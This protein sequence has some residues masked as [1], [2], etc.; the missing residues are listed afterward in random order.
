MPPLSLSHPIAA[1]DHYGEDYWSDQG[2]LFDISA[3]FHEER[4]PSEFF[5]GLANREEIMPELSISSTRRWSFKQAQSLA[6]HAT[7]GLF[8]PSARRSSIWQRRRTTKSR[9]HARQF[10]CRI[11]E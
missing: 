3:P 6:L 4:H 10:L 2:E 5:N 7:T 11:S 1:K 9:N 8:M